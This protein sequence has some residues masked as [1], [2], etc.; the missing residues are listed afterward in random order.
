[1]SGGRRS[2][3]QW[4][5]DGPLSRPG[6]RWRY[7]T[8]IVV[9]AILAS[10]PALVG[11]IPVDAKSEPVATLLAQI[12]AS[13]TIPYTGLASATGQLAVP[14]LGVGTDVTD[15][16]SRTNRLRVW[17]A[18]PNL[19][20]VDRV[21]AI[22]ESDVY[23][24]SGGVWQWDSDK[25]LAQ[26]VTNTPQVPLPGPQDALPGNLARRLLE[27][28]PAS[29]LT[30][31]DSRWIAGRKA[32]GLEWNPE[33]PTSLIGQ[34]RV[35]VD[36]DT[37]MPLA[38]D[39]FPVGSTHRAFSTAFLDVRFKAPGAS[40]LHFDPN[41]DPTATIINDE[42]NA[43]DSG[44]VRFVLPTAIA[45]L[46]QRSPPS[47]LVAT[48]GKG[49]SLVAVAAIDSLGGQALRQQVDS[50]SHPPIRGKFGTGSFISAPLLSGLIFTSGDRGYVL[51]GTVTRDQLEAM[52]LD[53]VRNPPQDLQAPV[54][55]RK[56]P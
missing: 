53:L 51:L 52:A 13:D 22:A 40:V 19:Y 29:Q 9:V 4:W 25:R 28:A 10:L 8:I 5:A 44:Q 2:L 54:Q 1:M 12:K 49:V 33:T 27:Q 21:T 16:I 47:P 38:V 45:G 48:Y 36:Q 50:P 18:S 56:T 23:Q 34:V 20:R 39:V 24:Q 30:S 37:G 7:S 42:P 15:L 3:R 43:P 31:I 11:A 41:N 35:W 46:P 26:F 6:A 14:D 17:W 55:P 32:L